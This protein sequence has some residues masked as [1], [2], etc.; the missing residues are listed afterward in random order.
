M[1][2]EEEMQWEEWGD[3]WEE[4][5]QKEKQEEQS[6]KSNP[7]IC[8]SVDNSK[9]KLPSAKYIDVLQRCFGHSSFRPIQ[10]E[11]IRSVIEDRNDN[12]VVVATGYGKSLLYQYPAVYTGGLSVVIS[13][14]ISLMQD[15]VLSLKMANIPA[16]FL[17]SA[18]K[19][20]AQVKRDLF[21]N[22]LRVLY[23]T[24]EYCVGSSILEDLSQKLNIILVAV[25]EAHC[26]SQWGHDFR[27]DYRKLGKVRAALPNIPFLAVTATA[28]PVVRRDICNSLSL[29]NPKVTC[30]SFD[31][32]NLYLSVSL[33]SGNPFLDLKK[34]MVKSS[35]NRHYK[36]DGPTII[37]CSTIKL[38]EELYSVLKDHHIVGDYY[39]GKRR[40]EDRNEVHEKFL[41]D[42]LNVIVATVAFG[43]GIDKPDVR[44]VIHFGVPKDIESY[45][46]EIG[47]AGRDGLPA[48]CHVFYCRKDF[49]VSEYL[50]G[51]KDVKLDAHRKEMGRLMER[52]LDSTACR[53]QS[54]LTHFEG[55]NQ[56]LDSK[57]NCCDNCTTAK[58][59]TVSTGEVS[60]H[61]LYD[62][63][64]DSELLLS[65][66]QSLSGRGLG[67]IVACLR[68]LKSFTESQKY[69]LIFG[70]GKHKSED[71]WK[72]LGRLL[73]REK[74]IEQTYK[75]FEFGKGFPLP[76]VCLSKSGQ[77]LLSNLQTKRADT[78][79][80]LAPGHEMIKL[81]AGIKRS[82]SSAQQSVESESSG[83]IIL[84]IPSSSDERNSQNSLYH[85]LLRVRKD[86]AIELE[87]APFHL[88]SNQALIDLSLCRP[89][90]IISLKSGNFDGFTDLKIQ[91]DGKFW[92]D[93]IVDFC[94]ENGLKVDVHQSLKDSSS[95]D[96]PLDTLS[97]NV[98]TSYIK[99]QKQKMT[100]EAVMAEKNI[101]RSTL[102]G[103]LTQ[104]L[105]LGLPFDLARAGVADD[106]L[107][108]ITKVISS[109]PINSNVGKLKPIKE[110]CPDFVTY[111]QLHIVV[112]YLTGRCPPKENSDMRSADTSTSRD[113]SSI[114][115]SS[116]ASTTSGQLRGFTS[117]SKELACQKTV[118]A[119]W[120]S[121]SHGATNSKTKSSS[122]A[123]WNGQFSAEDSNEKNANDT[124]NSY[125]AKVPGT[126]TREECRPTFSKNSEEQ[127]SSL[128]VLNEAHGASLVD[129]DEDFFEETESQPNTSSSN[130][131]PANSINQCTQD[132]K[133]SASVLETS[134]QSV[135]VKD[136]ETIL[137]R[138][139]S[140]DIPGCS[141]DTPPKRKMPQ[142]LTKPTAQAEIRKK[143]K[144][145]SLFKL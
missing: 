102:I 127:S 25:D 126:A 11:V 4:I 84:S 122:D 59:K 111:D 19:E 72:G 142:W 130:V 60:A 108:L 28:T 140:A 118:P 63:T 70:K 120:A 77:H 66:V 45:Y 131:Q 73:I 113:P 143:K 69:A 94:K 40:Q 15:Q 138:S 32:P 7:K 62:F 125:Q 95:D 121:G 86:R 3:V 97:L 81:I 16:A 43:M 99:F 41:R 61:N 30:S 114:Q 56:V 139:L 18:Q 132:I 124:S 110:Q 5:L 76:V 52:Y 51:S 109:P 104:A 135:S 21:E 9:S 107:Q 83:D 74:H 17:G 68:G 88:A 116:A 71:W 8:P 65:C 103:H 101:A 53:R 58:K 129:W 82:K 100:L 1:T 42:E 22:K 134:S 106:I 64:E 80:M 55:K 123:F 37:Y 136:D 39:H 79:V 117:S 96:S 35:D 87:C 31:R 93:H 20:S 144:N 89:S 57:E 105:K 119:M 98:Q 24:P 145:N 90:S 34:F 10:W 36:F 133:R 115:S 50:R 75:Q 46:Q 67:K 27:N 6:R 14:L 47:R 44:N 112:A 26:V 38:T 29:K 33:K 128:D 23:L 141:S 78:T 13:P 92:V 48:K 54:I 2:A 91:R 12:C 85:Y 137:K 49:A